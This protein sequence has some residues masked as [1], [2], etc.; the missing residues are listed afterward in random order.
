MPCGGIYKQLTDKESWCFECG[1][2][3]TTDT[4]S[5]YCEEWDCDIHVTC[6]DAFLDSPEGEIVLLHGHDIEM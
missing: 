5:Y 6:L 2:T 1:Q 3:I 4:E